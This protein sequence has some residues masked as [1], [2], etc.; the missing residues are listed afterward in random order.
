MTTGCESISDI[1]SILRA[2]F[3]LESVQNFFFDAA[4]DLK[5]WSLSEDPVKSTSSFSSDGA[6]FDVL[7]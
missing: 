6:L 4:D 2:K 1:S 7:V 3:L 5:K